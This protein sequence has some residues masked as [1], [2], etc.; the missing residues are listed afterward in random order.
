MTLSALFLPEGA[1]R[2]CHPS[3]LLCADDVKTLGVGRGRGRG[4]LEKVGGDV[5]RHAD[6]CPV[7]HRQAQIGGTQDCKGGGGVG[8][9]DE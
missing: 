6:T 2:S 3:I 5:G 4:E 9:V 8:V 7:G 1:S